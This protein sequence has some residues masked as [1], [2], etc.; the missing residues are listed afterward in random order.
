LS[1]RQIQRCRGHDEGQDSDD[2]R[3]GGQANAPNNLWSVT[4]TWSRSPKRSSGNGGA[5]YAVQTA[6]NVDRSW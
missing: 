4:M 6:V 1:K 3:C 5:G 2:Q